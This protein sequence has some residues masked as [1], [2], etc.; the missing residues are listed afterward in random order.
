MQVNSQP[1]QSR[2]PSL[3]PRISA[4]ATKRLVFTLPPIRANS[5]T[6]SEHIVRQFRQQTTYLLE[7]N[8]S[9]E[10]QKSPVQVLKKAPRSQEVDL[11]V[12][13][14]PRLV[15]ALSSQR[16]ELFL[17]TLWRIR[18]RAWASKEEVSNG[19][20]MVSALFLGSP[21][22]AGCCWRRSLDRLMGCLGTIRMRRI[23]WFSS[24]AWE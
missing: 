19:V 17:A 16:R 1:Y 20:P 12:K 15:S 2:L 9:P 23:G 7:Q 11:Y 24:W 18:L 8:L 22:M 3:Y 6:T 21:I 13:A 4:A 14:K 5:A 10:T